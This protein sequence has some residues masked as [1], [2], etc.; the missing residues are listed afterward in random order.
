MKILLGVVTV[1]FIIVLTGCLGPSRAEVDG[2]V[3]KEIA[4]SEERVI[5]EMRAERHRKLLDLTGKIDKAQEETR[6][7]RESDAQTKQAVADSA[8]ALI[9]A[10]CSTDYKTSSL[11]AATVYL[12]DSIA[13]DD[14]FIVGVD[15]T[16]DDVA[17]VINGIEIDD[18]YGELSKVCDVDHQGIWHLRTLPNR[19]Y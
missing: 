18:E 11:Y 13:R 17:G 9:T 6:Q 1:G 15:A 3:A 5:K 2:I 10:V 4:R 19:A 16:M 7:Y 14:V 12:L 8:R